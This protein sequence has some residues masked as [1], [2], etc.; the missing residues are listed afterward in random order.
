MKIFLQPPVELKTRTPTKISGSKSESNRLLI[1]QALYGNIAI[2][3]LSDSDD[4]DV[5]I[6]ALHSQ[7]EIIDIGHAGT[8]MRFLTAYF[9]VSE[10]REVIL[11]GS[12]R[13]QER[14]IGI[15][16]EA[17]KDLGAEIQYLKNEGF[18]PLKIKGKEIIKNQL[19]LKSNVSSQ[20][21]S[22]LLLIAPKLPYGLHLELE[23]E[24]VSASY[25][26]LTISLLKQIGVEVHFNENRITVFPKS[27]IK[28]STIQ[29]ESDWS[30]LSYFY[31]LMAL[32]HEDIVL[33]FQNFSEKSFQ[34]DRSLAFLYQGLGVHTV[35]EE[36][37]Q[38][39]ILRKNNIPPAESAFF[40][41][42]DSPDLAQTI[43]V[44]CFGLG[45]GCQLTGLQTLKIKETDR[46]QALKTELEKLGANVML[47]EDSLEFEPCETIHQ[48]IVIETYQDHRM[49]MAFAILGI[50][51]PVLIN[52]ADV[53]SKSYPG[54]WRDLEKIGLAVEV[55]EN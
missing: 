22:A 34:G 13:M 33:E 16:V 10:N 11:T 15:L 19:S 49:A 7:E 54:F 40:Y 50:K 52:D 21:I 29:V 31:S 24:P 1:L 30:S 41:L 25:I 3:N 12:K 36:K 32:T 45:M 42:A 5:L 18:P 14:P 51:T 23:D 4:T 26:E 47:T 8:A 38:T 27:E 43:A 28:D 35:F 44:T 17:L 48:N 2:G 39:V 9:A 37:T 20:F 46:L 6:D 55:H 53:V